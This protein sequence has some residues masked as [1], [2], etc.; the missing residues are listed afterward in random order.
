M[1]IV[2]PSLNYADFLAVTLPAWCR[3]ANPK[4]IRVVTHLDDQA[5]I[6]IAHSCGCR[7]VATTAWNAGGAILNKSR[8][9]DEAFGFIPP[10][11]ASFSNLPDR[12]PPEVHELCLALDADC[13]PVGRLPDPATVESKVIYGCHRYICETNE[14]LTG[15]LDGSIQR[16]NL[17][18]I[19]S[20]GRRVTSSQHRDCPQVACGYFQLFRYARG[21][22][23][24][25]FPAANEYDVRFAFKFP[26][27]GLVQDI[28]VLH[29]GQIGLNWKGRT[30]DPWPASNNG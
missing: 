22:R 8:A 15:Y 10:S 24:G 27:S 7:I 1:R 9:M 3:I 19:V 26:R 4:E 20:W 12:V 30:T 11:A 25:S 29:L 28:H 2:I 16:D 17:Q 6:D 14:I 23:F 13:Y 18:E 5:T 21:M